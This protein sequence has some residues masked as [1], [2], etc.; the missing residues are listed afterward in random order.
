MEKDQSCGR[1]RFATASRS[2][3]APMASCTAG[4]ESDINVISGMIQS[5]A[6]GPHDAQRVAI[7]RARS[8]GR[9]QR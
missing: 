5:N 8:N 3:L 7:W 1:T 2:T 9:D 4:D 6:N